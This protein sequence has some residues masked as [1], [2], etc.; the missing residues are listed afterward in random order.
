M[1]IDTRY[2]HVN[3]YGKGRIPIINRPAPIYNMGMSYKFYS[4]LKNMGVEIYTVDEDRARVVKPGKT[5]QSAEETQLSQIKGPTQ[6]SKDGAAEIARPRS[7]I[8]RL[9]DDRVGSMPQYDDNDIVL[10]ESDPGETRSNV[11]FKIYS[12][13]EIMSMSK[14]RLKQVLNVERK[15]QPGSKYYGAFHDR[16]PALISYVLATQE[17]LTNKKPEGQ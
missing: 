2:V 14:T 9:I 17:G 13:R 15:L 11:D 12:E 7:E 1:A 5:T 10:S 6:S 8:D 16:K 3:I 4:D